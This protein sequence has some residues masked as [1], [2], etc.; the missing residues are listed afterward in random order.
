MPA[1]LAILCVTDLICSWT[2]FVRSFSNFLYIKTET[3][4]DEWS[5]DANEIK[6]WKSALKS[7]MG[8]KNFMTPQQELNSWA[9]R[10]WLDALDNHWAVGDLWIVRSHS[11]VLWVTHVL[12][13][14]Q[15]FKICRFEMLINDRWGC[16]LDQVKIMKKRLT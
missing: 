7:N 6:K 12:P 5:C 13:V 3:Y 2:V 10:Y 1:V 11:E 4:N 9:A 16:D 15:R 8:K 14:L